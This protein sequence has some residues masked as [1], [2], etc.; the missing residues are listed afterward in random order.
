MQRQPLLKEQ[1]V[2]GFVVD[3]VLDVPEL[4]S[5]AVVLTH[6]QT[7]ARCVHLYNEDPN[8]LFC[9]G[10]RTP[11]W[12]NTGVPHILEHSVLAGSKKFPLKD[13]FKELLKVSLQ[14]FL[15]ALTYPDKTI[16]PVSSQ[17]EAD[18]FNLVDVYCDAVFHPLLTKETFFQEGW[19]FDVEN[20]DG[21]ID[22]KGIVYNEMKGVFSDF[23]SH[24]VRK[25]VSRLFPDTTYFFESG[26]EPEHITDLTYE[27]FKEFHCRFY[28]PSN[29]YIFL[30]GD[31]PTEKTLLF[32]NSGYL[33]E[34]CRLEVDSSVVFQKAWQK[35]RKIS[36]RAP[37]SKE[38]DGYASIII[39]WI[40]GESA[41]PVSA[42]LGRIFSHYFIDTHSSPL[43][44]A[45]IDSGLGEDLE[46]MSGFDADLGQ[47]IFSVGLRKTRPEHAKQIR[48]IV[49]D[50]LKK[51]AKRGFDEERLTGSLRQV[52]FWLREISDS[53]SFPYNLMLAERCY[54]SWMYGGDPLAHLCFKG[55]LSHIKDEKEKGSDFFV[56]KLRTYIIDNPHRLVSV[57]V[58]SSEMGRNLERQTEKQAVRL[59]R[60]FS[61]EQRI[62]YHKLTKALAVHQ[63]EE[64]PPGILAKIPQLKKS[65]MPGEGRRTPTVVG[66]ILSV[67]WYAHPLFTSGIVYFDI[68][69]DISSVPRDILPYLTIFS[70]MITRCGAAGLSYED[71]A[72][73]ISLSTGGISCSNICSRKVEDQD[74]LMFR[75]FFH[76]KALPERFGEMIEI[77]HDLFLSPDLQNVRQIREILLER[78][79]VLQASVIS[80]GH[81][82]AVL[83][84]ASRLSRSQSIDELINGI[85]QLRFLN[86]LIEK[87]DI[88][89]I[90][91]AFK[92]IHTTLINRS[93][94]VIS[95][96]YDDPERFAEPIKAWLSTLPLSGDEGREISFSTSAGKGLYGIEISSSV[97]F[98]SRVWRLN[99]PSPEEM[100]QYILMSRNLSTG[101][102]WEKIRVAGGAYGGMA[103]TSSSGAVF[104]CASYR[105]PNIGATLD[106]FET[107]LKNIAG[108]ISVK[109]IDQSI[110]GTIGKIDKPMTPHNRGFTET[111]NLLCGETSEYRQQIRNSVLFATPELLAKR[112]QQIL[113]EP[114][115]TVTVL[116]SAS[117]FNQ[118]ESGGKKFFRE[119]L[120][121]CQE[122]RKQ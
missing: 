9:I 20:P 112:A 120:L 117:A 70:E 21:K 121:P 19:H 83:Q 63:R 45:L 102:L 57:V 48:K 77:F 29:S 11:V 24:V 44:R 72:K 49:M 27:E 104:Y 105:D 52:E 66:K 40:F 42:M 28:H 38:N 109:E 62:M 34:Y 97:N 103:S 10:F 75:F 107:G 5:Q 119:E 76:G 58:A 59:S 114:L 67:P 78:R 18:F 47:S 100:G 2:H 35:P 8:N 98:V 3:R 1:A 17:V 80:N 37:S 89:S 46:D 33:S 86:R 74:G 118:A 22:I 101:Y 71:M 16:Y 99:N 7:G 39:S 54:R 68:G 95:M 82:F 79:N 116:A 56:Q 36:F 88:N 91:S 6:I 61:R 81:N 69:F 108:K 53:G 4:R 60:K 43:R 94:C 113:D 50:T 106:H 23:R 65:D 122:S 32:L 13:P 12:N 15:N 14:T 111:I 25:T 84:A 64:T 115:N 85:S 26:G 110:I 96:T 51:E 30:Y 93:T 73:R 92:R 31:I 41:D 87:D 90:I 55:P